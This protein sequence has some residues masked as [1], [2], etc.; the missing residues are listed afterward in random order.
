[1]SME[2]ISGK[3]PPAIGLDTV[4]AA[5]TRLSLV[6]GEAGRLVIAGQSVEH[7]AATASFEAAAAQLWA[8]VGLTLSPEAVGGA[9]AE[10]REEAFRRL[11]ALLP[12][13]RDLTLSEGLR[14]TLA[15]LPEAG[16]LP[17]ALR[18]T[19]ALPVF[20][21]ALARQRQGL[22]PVP[23]DGARGQA[24]DYLTLLR[25]TPP[26]TAEAKALERYL[27][28]VSDHGMNASTFVA[29]IIAS[30]RAG[31]TFAVAGA[32]GA[33]TGPLHGGAPEPV[34]DMLDAIGTTERIEPWI[35]A[36]LARGERLMGF[37]HRVYRG[38]DPRAD[39]LRATL[40]DLGV[41]SERM[42]FAAAVERAAL[43]GLA[44]TKPE[45]PLATNVEFY[46]A[47][48]LEALAIPREAFTATFAVGRVLGWT[49]HV[50]EQAREGRLIR[51]AARYVGALPL[52]A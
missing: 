14:L 40:L 48:L 4:V 10:A 8:L 24:T 6:D 52:S 16:S 32:F 2:R 18:I 25:G 42:D 44:R 19:G 1:M 23:P 26:S 20:A 35:D 29:R 45:R 31:M 12:A 3:R 33:L 5:E 43:A 30:T 21:A 11:P 51:P 34:L 9:L 41:R 47:L 7:L 15:A 13:T 17:P 50:L 38:R 27:V 36:A 39:V 46:T 37:G 28:T 22:P 49:A